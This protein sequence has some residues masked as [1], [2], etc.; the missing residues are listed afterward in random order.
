VN[1]NAPPCEVTPTLNLRFTKVVDSVDTT[2]P[3]SYVARYTM[4][5]RNVGGAAGAYTLTDTL[6]FTGDGVAF[7]GNALVSTSTGAVNPVLVGGAFAPANG[8]TVQLSATDTAIAPGATHIYA[9]AVPISVNPDT[10]ENGQCT[11][12]AGSGLFNAAS[13]MGAIDIDSEAC[14]PISVQG[15]PAI[16]LLKTVQLV[17]DGNANG[18]GDVGDVLNYALTISNV[19]VQPLSTLQLIDRFVT[20]LE[21]DPT[22]VG[23]QP[24]SV[25]LNDQVFFG[26]FELFGNGVLQPNDSVQCWA[27]HTLTADDVLARRVVNVATTSGRGTADEVVTS[28][29]T[30]IYSAFP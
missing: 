24:I 15:R 16:R 25:L 18:Y 9:L 3:G 8:V 22:T 29:S 21:C 17:V 19:G 20:D 28:T 12:S 7:N 11:G 26:T 13:V 27:T 30:A 14:A 23:G 10:L 5:V 6:G 2:G 4:T 1:P